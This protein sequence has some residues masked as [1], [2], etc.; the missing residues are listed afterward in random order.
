MTA[1][2]PNAAL[3]AIAET[4]LIWVRSPED[5][6][7]AIAKAKTPKAARYTTRLPAEVVWLDARALTPATPTSNAQLTAGSWTSRRASPVRLSR[8]RLKRTATGR[9][10][11]SENEWTDAT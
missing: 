5:R 6:A 2:A 11:K 3:T 7:L 4:T 1:T 8:A 9:P 10:R